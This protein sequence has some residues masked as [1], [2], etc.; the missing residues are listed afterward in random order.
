[1]LQAASLPPLDVLARSLINELDQIE[2]PFILVLDDYHAIQ[3]MDVHHLLTELFRYP[4]RALHL[5]LASRS[6]PPLSLTTLRARGQATEIRTQ[7]LRFTEAETATFLQQLGI[8][9]DEG[10]VRAL[11]ERVEGWVTGMRLAVLSSRHRGS[12]DLAPAHVERGISYVTDYLVA[13]VLE[14]QPPAIQDYLLRTSVLERFCAPLCEAVCL[15]SSQGA[16]TREAE[17][18]EEAGE[19]ELAGRPI[20]TGWRRATCS[21]SPWM[22]SMSGT[23]TI[24]CSRSSCATSCSAGTGLTRLPPSTPEPVP[25]TPRMA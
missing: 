19:C 11:V 14:G 6:D 20:W 2:Q 25:G 4:P 5:V 24:I 21:W 12:V 15:G 13:E 9:A 18:S 3:N 8:P 1:M 23:A 7:E 17:G 16:S 22:T 10:T